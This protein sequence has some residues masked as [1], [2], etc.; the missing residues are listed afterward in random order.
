MI[1]W[2]RAAAA[3]VE[4]H[5][6][7]L[8]ALDAAI[9]DADHGANVTRGFAAALA[10]IE[11]DDLDDRKPGEV[12][13]SVAMALISNVGGAAGPLYGTF[14]LRFAAALGDTPELSDADLAAAFRAGI[15]GLMARGKSRSGEK[16][17]IDALAPAVAALEAGVAGG[18]PLGESLDAAAEAA[19]QGMLGTIPLVATKGRA[20]YLGE[21]AIG[22][23]DPGATSAYLIV[24]AAAA[25]LA[26]DRPA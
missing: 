13:K 4:A 3:E 26:G 11:A 6:D 14:F 20:S 23:Q 22:H 19:R 21:R 18:L 25:T 2:M 17:M 7:E 12:A 1:D 10:K 5:R 16:T 9:G 15:N 8:T 24:R